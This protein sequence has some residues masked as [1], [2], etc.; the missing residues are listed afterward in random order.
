MFFGFGFGLRN[1]TWKSRGRRPVTPRTTVSTLNDDVLLNIFDW[2]RLHNTTD[3]DQGWNLERW[4]YKPIHVCQKWRHLIL[5]SPT[6]LDLH[7]VCTYG[8]PVEAML[9]HSPPLP[10]IIFYPEITGKTSAA[11]EE[12]ALFALQQRERVRRIQVTATTTI[13]CNLF[14]AMDNEFPMLERLALHSSTESRTGLMLPEKLQAP[15]L[16][17][18]TLS[19]IAFPI[20]SMLLRQADGLITLRLWNVPAS[21][22]FHP[23]HLVAQLSSMSRLEILMIHFYTA[24]PNR[25]VE[26]RPWS[27]QSTQIILPGLK[28]L[29]FRG[30]SVYLEEILAR[31]SAPL[32]SMLN[33]EFF[34]QFTFDLN[35]LRK[36]VHKIGEFKFCSAEMHFDKDFVSVIVDPDLE[37]DGTYPLVVQV[38]CL[39][40]DWQAT[41]AGQICDALKSLLVRVDSLTLGFYKDDPASWQDE[42][43]HSQWHRLL[44]TF[45]G[46][47][48]LQL[49]GGLVGDFFRSLKL[50]EGELPSEL[51]P[52]LRELV[53][54][55][56]GHT[57]D[58]FTSFISAR[59]SA[60]RRIRLVRN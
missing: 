36:F 44:Q 24:I 53:S 37:R 8:I 26:R 56:W 20:K 51:L 59:Q 32:L 46:V 31:L 14:K 18:L 58:A 4:W 9:S 33:V 25:K 40:L 15:P 54:R 19:N 47:K 43:D 28:I 11:D 29:A 41:C 38:K 57:D 3:E 48:T 50:D 39:P 10:I 42:I 5:S 17:H 23:T 60:G 12:G 21:P 2:Y 34:N 49:T 55:G 30:S 13:L 6:R 35:D 22:E 45:A 52:E 27:V 16:R 7:L 1:S